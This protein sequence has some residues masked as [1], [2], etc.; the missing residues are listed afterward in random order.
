ML[1]HSIFGNIT[2]FRLNEISNTVVLLQERD[3][4]NFMILTREIVWV[5]VTA[6]R[7]VKC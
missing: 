5:L 7:E 4:K 6:L 3:S 1:T 2:E